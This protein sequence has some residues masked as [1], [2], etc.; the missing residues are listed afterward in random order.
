MNRLLIT[1]M[2]A[3][4]LLLLDAPTAAA[5]TEIRTLQN[6]WAHYPV[7]SRREQQLPRWLKKNPSFR[8]WYRHSRLR[9]NRY[10]SWHQLF[11]IYR[12]ERIEKRRYWSGRAPVYDSRYPRDTEFRQRRKHRG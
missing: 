10:L 9:K 8:T 4:G 7:E 6:P 5:H 3:G 12:W 2:L 1:A 11:D